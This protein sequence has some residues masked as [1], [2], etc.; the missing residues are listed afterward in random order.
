MT[1]KDKKED[2]K[3]NKKGKAKKV[4]YSKIK[5]SLEEEDERDEAIRKIQGKFRQK[6]ARDNLKR[7]IKE[8]YVKL[9]D[10]I[11]DIYVYKNKQ[12][13]EI[14]QEKLAFLGDDDLPDP[15]DYACPN[16]YD[17]I[18][19]NDDG[20]AIVCTVNTF[21]HDRI[22]K[23]SGVTNSDHAALSELFG[24]TLICKLR[25]ENITS[26]LNPTLSDF[27]VALDRVRRVAKKKSFLVIYMCT[28]V[29]TAK[30]GN[31]IFYIFI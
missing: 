23:I 22:P 15:I 27:T 16:N 4:D 6:V 10:R 30:G 13:G 5:Y 17:P 11:N 29:I 18:E 8:N 19:P 14:S 25:P 1:K 12:T 26:I 28:H 9:Y 21:Q 20:Y 24:H 2:K 31:I 7:L 3:G